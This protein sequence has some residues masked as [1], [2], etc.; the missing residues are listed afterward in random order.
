M[1]MR[2]KIGFFLLLLTVVFGWTGCGDFEYTANLISDKDL[3]KY[4]EKKYDSEF[5]MTARVVTPFS[6]EDEGDESHSSIRYTFVDESGMESHI[7]RTCRYNM[8]GTRYYEYTDDYQVMYLRNHPELIADLYQGGF[9]IEC[10]TEMTED[11]YA[12]ATYFVVIENSDEVRDAM[13]LV[14]DVLQNMEPLPDSG[15]EPGPGGIYGIEAERPKVRLKHWAFEQ[16]VMTNVEYSF[17]TESLVFDKNPLEET[18]K[19]VEIMS[20]YAAAKYAGYGPGWEEHLKESKAYS[21]SQVFYRG[22][23]MRFSLE[24]ED[25]YDCYVIDSREAMPQNN[26]FY[27]REIA[28][29]AE[30]LGFAEEVTKDSVSFIK[31]TREVVFRRDGELVLCTINGQP[32]EYEGYYTCQ[33]GDYSER[34]TLPIAVLTESDLKEI[35]G[36]RFEIDQVLERAIVSANTFEE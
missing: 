13:T 14:M 7:Y 25:D 21:I 17:P 11:K 32:Y 35:F 22:E 16:T 15:Y 19:A 3:E 30:D 27:I 23:T 31:G 10:E 26:E 1:H 18:S 4:L 9:T 6:E 5:T 12:T 2:V 8:G 33:T 36:I 20:E 28:W 34:N 24:Y 29:L